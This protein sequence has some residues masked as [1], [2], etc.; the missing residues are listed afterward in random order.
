[1][2]TTTPTPTPE[3][4]RSDVARQLEEVLAMEAGTWR[5]VY[6]FEF[7]RDN[8][9]TLRRALAALTELESVKQEL[10]QLRE[11]VEGA[12]HG[13]AGYYSRPP[14]RAVTGIA[15]EC[16]ADAIERLVHKRVLIIPADAV[17]VSRD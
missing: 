1:M 10:S 9:D 15:I 17:E 13:T 12:T 4:L 3:S 7:V 2:D 14:L 8:A 6:H 5:H 11:A 16:T